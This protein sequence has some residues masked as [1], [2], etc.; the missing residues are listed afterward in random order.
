MMCLEKKLFN[1]LKY[2][3]FIDNKDFIINNLISNTLYGFTVSHKKGYMFSVLYNNIKDSY[4]LQ[5]EDFSLEIAYKD[6]FKNYRID[7]KKA[8]ELIES[9]TI[10]H[11]R[12][13]RIEKIYK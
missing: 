12:K 7:I 10:T 11:K 9:Q 13:E 8:L 5:N 1:I 2:E 6:K 4:Y 3:K